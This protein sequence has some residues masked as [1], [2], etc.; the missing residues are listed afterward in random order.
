[1][2][3][4]EHRLKVKTGSINFKNRQSRLKAKFYLVRTP[5]QGYTIYTNP[6]YLPVPERENLASAA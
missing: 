1:L 3:F 4:V 6:L 5:G 2:V